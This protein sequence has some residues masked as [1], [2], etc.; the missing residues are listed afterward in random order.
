MRSFNEAMLAKQIWRPFLHLARC[1]KAKYHP[2]C[3]V[4]Q[5]RA[6]PDPSYSWKSIH[7]QINITS[8]WR[9]CP[10]ATGYH[11]I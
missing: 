11:S 6:G 8:M 5:A 10:V 3:D 9:K 7:T 4:L 1:I 2:D